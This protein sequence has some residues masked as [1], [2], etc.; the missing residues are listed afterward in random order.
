[1]RRV[2]DLAYAPEHGFRGLLDVY[3]PREGA[4]SAPVLFQVHGGAWVLSQKRHQARP[5]MLH[6]ARSG[7]VCV[8]VNY[9]L[10]PRVAL[11]EHLIDLKRALVWVKQHVAEYGG[12]PELVV[13]TGGSAGGH[14]CSLLALTANDPRYQPGFE[15]AD[16]SVSACVPFYGVYDLSDHYGRQQHSG[17]QAF[18]AR[19]VIQKPLESHRE[20]WQELSPMHR[21]HAQAPPFFVLQGSHDS[22]TPVEEARHF[23]ELLRRASREPVCYAEIPGAQHAFDTFHSTRSFHA[24][25][26]VE[27]FLA[28]VVSRE[29]AR[30]TAPG[31]QR[32]LA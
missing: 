22:L 7:W 25:R 19:S 27:R 30:S 6:L 10:S 20:L 9:R 24:V 12:D 31:P 13:A 2:D 32:A 28:W 4:R 23:V 26:G 1:M 3:L 16:T 5:L 29:R 8:A 15:A 14:L 21:A 17:L 11:P 18:L